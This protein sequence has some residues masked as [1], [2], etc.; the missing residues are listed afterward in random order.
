M[1]METSHG[2]LNFTLRSSSW[3]PNGTRG[4]DAGARKAGL[5][6]MYLTGIYDPVRDEWH[7]K[8]L[9]VEGLLPGDVDGV[10]LRIGPNPF[11]PPTGDY[12]L[13]SPSA[14]ITSSSLWGRSVVPIIGP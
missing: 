4:R 8:D 13:V 5:N 11:Y 14:Y 12:H 7:E 3:E 1:A 10:F 9:P 6:N 2:D